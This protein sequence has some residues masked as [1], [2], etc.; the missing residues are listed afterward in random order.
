MKNLA[1]NVIY[2]VRAYATNKAGTGYGEV[3]TFTTGDE[4][5]T[6]SN[7]VINGEIKGD[8]EINVTYQYHDKEGNPESGTVIQWY[9]ADDASGTGKIAIE[10]ATTSTYRINLDDQGKV[11]WVGITPHS[12]AG[13][14]EGVEVESEKKGPIGEVTTVTFMYDNHEVTYGIIN[15]T[16]T[17]RRWLDRNLGAPNTP[18]AY[19]D[20]VNLGDLFQWGRPA[21][22]HQLVIRTPDVGNAFHG[23]S[24]AVNTNISTILS[25]TDAPGNSDFIKPSVDPFDWRSPQNNDLWQGV[26]GINNPCP[27]GWRIPTID[28][29]TAEAEVLSSDPVNN[30]TKLKLTNSGKRFVDTGKFGG[31]NGGGNYWS[32]TVTGLYVSVFIL[33]NGLDPFTFGDN[34]GTANAVKCIKSE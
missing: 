15:S 3:R 10:G 6:A 20:Y 25:T 26:N 24:T 18:S 4:A 23:L 21:D 5:P 22:G 9:R 2:Y 13:T 11:I 1:S 31:T 28:E 16:K 14:P 7:I 27:A 34:R 12:S 17:G 29:W 8:E 33:S 32:S 19:N 30:F